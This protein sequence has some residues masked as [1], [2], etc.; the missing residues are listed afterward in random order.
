MTVMLSFG[1]KFP[2]EQWHVRWH[3]V[4]MQQP[5]LLLPKFKANSSH[6]FMKSP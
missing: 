6:I 3:T 1:K 2:G 5:V 4:I